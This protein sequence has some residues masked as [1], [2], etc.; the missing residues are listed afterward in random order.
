MQVLHH[1]PTTNIADQPLEFA[2]SYNRDHDPHMQSIYGYHDS[3]G[4]IRGVD[5]AT[6]VPSMN[7]WTASVAP[8]AA[9]PP[10]PPVMPSGPQV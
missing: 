4:P 8:G 7:S 10:M 5:P 9:Y 1:M 2:P 3:V 6:V